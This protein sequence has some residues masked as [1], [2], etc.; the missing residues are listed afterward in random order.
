MI[1]NQMPFFVTFLAI[2]VVSGGTAVARDGDLATGFGP[3]GF[4]VVTFDAGGGLNDQAHAIKIQ[5]DGRIL[6][7]GLA[8]NSAGNYDFALSR[9]TTTG[10]LDTSFG[11]AGKVLIDFALGGFDDSIKA[12]GLQPDGK[13]VAVGRA[14]FDAGSSDRYA[15]G[16]VRLSANGTPDLSFDL[17]G[18]AVI[19]FDPGGTQSAEAIGVVIQT[20][21]KIV[22]VGSSM[23]SSSS[24]IAL[25]R[26]NSDGSPDLSFN[27]TGRMLVPLPT[28]AI[29]LD[30]VARPSGELVLGG[31][32]FDAGLT[33]IDMLVVQLTSD[34]AMDTSFGSGGY[35]Q[36]AFDQGGDNADV[37]RSVA[38]DTLGRVVL[39]GSVSV[40]ESGAVQTKAAAV[41]LS[42]AGALDTGFGS[43][44]RLLI[45][46]QR[47][48]SDIGSSAEGVVIDKLG[49]VVIAGAAGPSDNYADQD[50]LV[51][52]L[53]DDGTLDES[54]AD[55]GRRLVAI[56]LGPPTNTQDKA[57]D[58]AIDDSGRIIT[59]GLEFIDYSLNF[60]MLSVAL[61]G[62]T[63][64]DD[65]FD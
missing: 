58:V 11:S 49:R 32:I 60:D 41:R 28:A 44:G 65:G 34:G 37:G 14:S 46:V 13:I 47:A 16:V 5:P 25:A 8:S 9:L 40:A 38:L 31:A 18:S 61:V 6:L 53:L 54:F 35:R 17:D 39:A 63:L 15:F 57:R 36:I 62:D 20:D 48:G 59:A 24:I 56:D 21:G 1:R 29:P 30:I 4:Q 3:G 45:P 2:A 52:R 22:I 19:D 10:A 12:I 51:T 26:L 55:A 33:N 27:G 23:S 43:G 64:F 7:G 50:V 42:A